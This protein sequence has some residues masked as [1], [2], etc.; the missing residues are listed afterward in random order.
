MANDPNSI[1]S[2]QKL[3]SAIRMIVQSELGKSRPVPRYAT[4]TEIN[5][6]QRYCMVIY[7]G[8]TEA[9]RV[10][11]AD[12]APSVVGQ[13]VRINGTGSDRYIEAIRGYNDTEARTAVN[14]SSLAEMPFLLGRWALENDAN[15]NGT[16]V[17]AITSPVSPGGYDPVPFT[18]NN[19]ERKFLNVG[20]R[21][22]VPVSGYYRVDIQMRAAAGLYERSV[23]LAV[24][25]G[26]NVGAR[27]ITREAKSSFYS[28]EDILTIDLPYYV[29]DMIYLNAGDV[30]VPM[31]H[32]T[33]A[34]MV[35]AKIGAASV[36]SMIVELR[37]RVDKYVI[38]VA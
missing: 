21:V 18:E 19:V 1:F 35:Y 34:S 23:I 9:V 30:I 10:P 32:S 13:E 4:V 5:R 25:P 14:E 20:G 15:L 29:T 28:S 2:A 8:E 37:R 36:T 3:E 27:Y 6:E 38:P 17:L 11:Y 22:T 26:G 16:Q 31:T 7:I 24:E 12:I 33:G